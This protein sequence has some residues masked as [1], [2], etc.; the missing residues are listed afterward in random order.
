[1]SV[2]W[3]AISPPSCLPL[4]MCRNAVGIL[5]NIATATAELA[6]GRGGPMTCG[7]SKVSRN[8]GASPY[9]IKW[10]AYIYSTLVGL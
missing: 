10:L 9:A 8:D 4:K 1:M 6:E 5:H 7:L 2:A 3:A